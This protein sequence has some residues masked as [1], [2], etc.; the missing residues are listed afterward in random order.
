MENFFSLAMVNLAAV[1]GL[2]TIGWIISLL[3]RDVTIVDSLWGLGFVLVALITFRTGNGFTARS[4]LVLI[5]T[6]IWGLRLA[7]YLTRRNWGKGEDHRYGSWR[8][9]S[10]HRFWI[11]SLFKVFWLQAIFLWA[12]SLVLQ[13]AQASPEPARITALDILGTLVWAVG[14]IFESVGDWQLAQFK[15]DADNRGRVMDRGLWAWSRHPNYFGE[16]LVWWGFFLVALAT[17]EG[18]WTVV[19][20]LIISAVLLKMTGVPLTEAALKARRPGYAEY[21]RRT[22]AFFPRPPL[23]DVR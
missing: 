13:Q 6:S 9:K 11:V 15:A 1:A 23:K 2:M 21:I 10:G 20:P 14:L 4:L 5:L 19:S 8:E 17:K 22:S 12:I 7:G 16:F 3:R 18:W